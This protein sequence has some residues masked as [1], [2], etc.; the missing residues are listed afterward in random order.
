LYIYG[1]KRGE[2]IF[3]ESLEGGGRVMRITYNGSI[4]QQNLKKKIND[5]KK[6]ISYLKNEIKKRDD[7]E[8]FLTTWILNKIAW[9]AGL[10]EDV[11]EATFR[12]KIIFTNI[13]KHDGCI[14][15]EL[16]VESWRERD[17]K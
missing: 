2:V 14:N 16:Q 1:Y 17:S 8:E 4:K 11:P 15:E 3:N 10:Y 9:H 12:N 5:L 7:N 13:L 6:E